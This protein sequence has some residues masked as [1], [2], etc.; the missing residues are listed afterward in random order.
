MNTND[1]CNDVFDVAIVGYGPTGLA[2]A[3]WLGKA[4]HKTVVIERW[5]DLYM[6][7]RAGH[8]D[9]EVMRLFQKMGV[10]ET[11]ARD[12]AV[13]KTAIIKGMDGKEIARAIAEESDQGWKSRY[14][15]YQPNLERELDAI[16]R[17]TGG[18]TILQGWLAE[19][20]ERCGEDKVSIHIASGSGNDG[21]W[22]PTGRRREVAARWLIGADGANSVVRKFLQSTV[23]DLGYQARALVIFVERLDPKV[24]ETM[25]DT[26]IAMVLPRPYV[27]F[28]ESGKRFARWEFS[29]NDGESSAEMST[30]SKAWELIG[31]WGFTPDNARL[32][33]H[34]VFDFRTQVVENWREGNILL[35]G[36]AA[37]V[38]PPFQG[39]GMCSGQ[40]DAAALTWRLDLVMRGIADAALL[41]S[42]TDERK[43][44]VLE[45]TKNSSERG[46]AFWM[47]DP[48]KARERDARMKEG[49][50]SDN[51]KKRS[52]LIPPLVDGFL[53]RGKDGVVS[54]A[55]RLSAQFPVR[56]SGRE[57][58]LDEFVGANWLLL[59]ADRSLLKSLSTE[60]R[61]LLKRLDART[62]LLGRG[63]T[64]DEF[65]DIDGKYARWLSGIGWQLVLI[66]PDSYIFG[67]ASE[68]NG[69]HALFESFR[70]QLH[71]KV[72]VA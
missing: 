62:F 19:R 54:P 36:D 17:D 5:P 46:Q 66:R 37:H 67:G 25:P 20:I 10:A 30:A 7:P 59:S 50:V 42:Y 32:I 13:M 39:Q 31:R 64:H 6:L 55:G 70:A 24:G 11:I 52:G 41:D 65:E 48:D 71:L 72:E 69:V 38:M 34:S 35:A 27:A 68:A 33:R 28:R 12:S 15:L 3:Y 44:H 18:V 16:V 47:T 43:P 9:G 49:Q 45:L 22:T 63:D 1:S 51:L 58:L 53:M 57:A 61:E 2:L 56:H 4:G 26:E 21:T 60:E 40:R 8:V 29:V 23:L 14:S